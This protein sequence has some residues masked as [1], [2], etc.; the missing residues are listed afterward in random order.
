MV[1]DSLPPHQVD[2]ILTCV[3]LPEAHT[4]HL[5]DSRISLSSKRSQDDAKHLGVAGG[6][7]LPPETK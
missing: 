5:N 3:S 4:R 2:D 7:N 1:R 6:L